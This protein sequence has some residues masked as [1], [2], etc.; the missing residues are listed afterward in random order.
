MS[1]NDEPRAVVLRLW[2]ALARR[3]WDAV[4]ASLT[5]DCIYLDV[6]TGPTLAAKGPADTVK[7]LRIGLAGLAEYTNHDGLLVAEGPDVIYEHSETWVWPTGERAELPFVSV[8]RVR[9]GRVSLWKDYWNFETLASAAP[10]T[11]LADFAAAD[12]S[13][14]YDATAELS[15]RRAS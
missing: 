11:W 12:M 3:D 15:I 5:E 14:I 4:A 2:A 6:P 1:D 9:D 13:W 10:S 8:H 7:R